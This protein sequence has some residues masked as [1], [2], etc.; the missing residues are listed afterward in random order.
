MALSLC[1]KTISP[2]YIPA[3]KRINEIAKDSS[4]DQPYQLHQGKSRVSIP[5]RRTHPPTRLTPLAAEQ[6]ETDSADGKLSA[7][8]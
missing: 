8:P 4:P 3:Q 2:P 1:D 6:I 7:E 5:R